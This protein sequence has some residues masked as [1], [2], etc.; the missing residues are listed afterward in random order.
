MCISIYIY[1]LLNNVYMRIINERRRFRTRAN[2]STCSK[3]VR[4]GHP[5]TRDFVR[6]LIMKRIGSRHRHRVDGRLSSGSRLGTL[7]SRILSTIPCLYSFDNCLSKK[8]RS[9]E[10]LL[11]FNFSLGVLENRN[12]KKRDYKYLLY[13]KN[14]CPPLRIIF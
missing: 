1:I 3:H 5:W 11:D 4:C 2:T 7:V 10:N 12:E 14:P 9:F 13:Q 6:A 8:I